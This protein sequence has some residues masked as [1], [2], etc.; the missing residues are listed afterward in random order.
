MLPGNF[1]ASKA[2]LLSRPEE[3]PAARRALTPQAPGATG[4]P[5]SF[6]A[7]KH[8][9][10]GA[11]N[12][13]RSDAT[14]AAAAP[15]A[16]VQ[17]GSAAD[18]IQLRLSRA[19][20]MLKEGFGASTASAQKFPGSKL[21]ERRSKTPMSAHFGDRSAGSDD[22]REDAGE[23]TARQGGVVPIP[24]RRVTSDI[25]APALTAIPVSAG[26]SGG[27]APGGPIN[28]SVF[29]SNLRQQQQQHR[30]VASPEL[31]GPSSLLS[32]QSILRKQAPPQVG[33]LDSPAAGGGDSS[34]A[35]I[36]QGRF[37]QPQL[38]T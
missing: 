36:P 5:V 27:G 25:V 6:G 2:I 4:T 11:A 3:P 37:S 21:A 34:T 9:H 15:P 17:S 22:R 38:Y 19:T 1:H 29:L 23:V 33:A 13:W 12:A 10:Q 30:V 26:L 35:Q 16:A 28:A 32:P 18:D 8:L 14:P 31:Q 24:P 20:N 7:T